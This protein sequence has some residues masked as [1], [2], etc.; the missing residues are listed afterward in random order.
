MYIRG[1]VA[2]LRGYGFAADDRAIAPV[3]EFA[4]GADRRVLRYGISAC[5]A[6][7]RRCGDGVHGF[8]E[9]RGGVA[10]ECAHD[11]I[12]IDMRGG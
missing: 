11:A 7:V 5:R 4:S 1:F 3:H 12:G 8:A 10:G 2:Y 9:P 6:L